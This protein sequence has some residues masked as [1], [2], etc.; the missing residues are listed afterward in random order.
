MRLRIRRLEVRILPSALRRGNSYNS[1]C[2][3]KAHRSDSILLVPTLSLVESKPG[4]LWLLVDGWNLSLLSDN[5]SPKTIRSYIDTLHG[6]GDF[7][8]RQKLPVDVAHIRREHAESYQADQLKHFS[9]ATAALRHRTLKVFFTWLVSEGEIPTSP[10]TGM[11]PPKVG[12][13]PVPTVSKDSMTRLL[14]ACSANSFDDR[15]DHAILLLFLDTGLRLSEMSGLSVDDVDTTGRV[16]YVT[17]KGN[18]GRSVRYGVKAG[19]A[20]NRYQRM[21]SRHPKSAE[22]GWWL[23]T[24]GQ[25]TPSGVAQMVRRRCERAGIGQVHPHQ[26]RHTFA[27]EWMASGG[28]KGDLMHLAGWSSRD[29]LQR[30]GR[31]TATERALEAHDRHSPGDR[32]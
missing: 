7:A 30:Y 8:L 29:M 32:L 11:S 26:F 6:F 19:A 20:L 14:K 13:V 16:L 10:M 2:L 25:M 24:K 15:R 17:G 23:G 21:R 9:A 12:E 31:Y 4:D 28:S 22:P 18:K 3:S 27:A 1:G 5:K